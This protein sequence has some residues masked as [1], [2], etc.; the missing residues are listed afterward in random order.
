MPDPSCAIEEI[1]PDIA[2]RWLGANHRN[3]SLSNPTVTRLAGIIIRGEWMEDCTDAIGLD[4]DEGVINGQHRLNAVIEADQAVRALV[5]RNVS[6]DVIK[7]ID[8][9]MHRTFGQLLKMNGY[10]YAPIVAGAV[11]WLYKMMNDFERSTPTAQKGTVPQLLDVLSDHEHVVNSI[12]PAFTAWSKVRVDRALLTAYHYTCASVDPDKADEFFDQL[13]SGVGVAADSPVYI[14]RERFLAE[15]AKADGKK[16][17]KYV[18]AAWLIKAWEA[19]RRGETMTQRQLKWT[20]SGPRAEPFP[21]V[22]G[23]PWLPVETDEPLS[24]AS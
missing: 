19:T 18:L 23:V 13:A 7:I 22:T 9:G 14:L 10:D 21:K 1:T 15:Q 12:D 5:L 8:Q 11:D 6:P 20:K 17:T 16:E 4:T 3:R 24:P 2:K